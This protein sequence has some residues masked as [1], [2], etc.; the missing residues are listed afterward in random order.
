MCKLLNETHFVSSWRGS[1]IVRGGNDSHVLLYVVNPAITVTLDVTDPV[2]GSKDHRMSGLGYQVCSK[3]GHWSG[4]APKCVLDKAG[5]ANWSAK[6]Q[7]SSPAEF[8]TFLKNKLN[9][10]KV[11]KTC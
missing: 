5:T 3:Q 11:R 9:T 4:H 6:Q 8:M 7:L 1:D 2:A 10:Y